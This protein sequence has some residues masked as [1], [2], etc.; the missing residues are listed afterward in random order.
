MVDGQPETPMTMPVAVEQMPASE[1]AALALLAAVGATEPPVV[2][3]ERI[4]AERGARLF[5][6]AGLHGQG[7]TYPSHGELVIKVSAGLPQL[8]RRFTLAHEIGHTYFYE[9]AVD[10]NGAVTARHRVGSGR[11]DRKEEGWCNN[12]AGD[13]LTP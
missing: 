13:L 9:M 12:F 10:E 1:H 7:M 3:F 6:I 8:R 5:E 11:V 4:A 2:S